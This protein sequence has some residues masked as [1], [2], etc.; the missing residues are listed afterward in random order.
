MNIS[1][2]DDWM[3]DRIARLERHLARVLEPSELS[4]LAWNHDEK[5][6]RIVPG[7]LSL[8][9]GISI[10]LNDGEIIPLECTAP[11]KSIIMDVFGRRGGQ[12]VWIDRLS[13]LAG[14]PDCH[15]ILRDRL[16]AWIDLGPGTIHVPRAQE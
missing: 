10:F 7:P 6:V 3:Y 1:G 16:D 15:R 12:E 11:E 2:L 9:A 14:D 8:E 5:R 13:E 4:M